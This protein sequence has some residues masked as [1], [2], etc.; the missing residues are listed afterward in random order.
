MSITLPFARDE[1]SSTKHI[2]LSIQDQ[3]EITLATY[4]T[5][6]GVFGI[7]AELYVHLILKFITRSE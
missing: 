3:W 5:D 6:E 7:A 4:R 2:A 1:L